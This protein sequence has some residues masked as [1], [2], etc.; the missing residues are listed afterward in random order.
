MNNR[1]LE[2]L[3]VWDKKENVGMNNIIRASRVAFTIA[4]MEGSDIITAPHVA[5]AITYRA[6]K[7]D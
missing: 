4:C 6:I 7:F 3:N 2:L 5:E 1:A